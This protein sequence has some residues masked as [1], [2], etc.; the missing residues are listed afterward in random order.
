MLDAKVWL[1]VNI[2]GFGTYLNN[3]LV[4][5]RDQSLASIIQGQVTGNGG[6][7]NEDDLGYNQRRKR[8]HAYNRTFVALPSAVWSQGDHA[9]GLSLGMRSYT[10]VRRLPDYMARFIEHGVTDYTVQHGID[11]SLKNLNISSLTFAEI[12][13]SYAHTF[14]KQG[15]NMFMGGITISK[16]FSFAG[17]AANIN[18][19]NFNVADDTLAHVVNLNADAMYALGNPRLQGK[20]GLGLDI[21]FTYQ[22]MLADARY[23]RPNSRKGGCQRIPYLFKLGVSII[24]IGSVKFDPSDVQYAGYDFSDYDWYGYAQAEADENN[25]TGFFEAQESDI[26]SGNVRKTNKVRLP[27][28]ASIQFDYN[29]WASRLYVNGTIIQGLPVSKRKFGLRHANSLTI[30]PRYETYWF[31]AALPFSLYEYQHP[32]LG[33]SLRFGPVTIGSDKVINW[34]VKSKLYGGDIYAH[35]KIP[36]RYHPGCRTRLKNARKRSGNPWKK[37]DPCDAFDIH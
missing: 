26:R 21:G 28:F 30:T 13:G 6:Q 9:A 16:F 20:G 11:Y 17:A 25:P 36:I 18:E 37:R 19:F 5:V 15:R 12:K 7:I 23:Y 22:H 2:V 1:D 29:V 14:K 4:Y 8:Y 32:Q 10:G 27:T 24:D 3:D 33:L 31:E 35:V 34:F